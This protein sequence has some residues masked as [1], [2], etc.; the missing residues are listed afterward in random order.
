MDSMDCV[1]A[2]DSMAAAECPNVRS[3]ARAGKTK[4]QVADAVTRQAPDLT[5]EEAAALFTED[6]TTVM[7]RNVTNRYIPE[8]FVCEVLDAGFEG[9]FDFFYLPMDF[10]T[11]RNRGYCFLNFHSASCARQFMQIF[12]GRKLSRYNTKKSLQIVPAALQ[13]LEKNMSALKGGADR[14]KNQWFRPMV[15][16]DPSV[17]ELC[18]ED[19]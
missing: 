6:T 17:E 7:I 10:S 4:R 5:L 12:H 9:T 8:E 13:G 2:E 3:R 11:K 16:S 15:F 1:D 14:I 18:G 19:A